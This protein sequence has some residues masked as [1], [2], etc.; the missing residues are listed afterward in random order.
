MQLRICTTQMHFERMFVQKV[1]K[2]RWFFT[3]YYLF[4]THSAQL[5]LDVLSMT[6][7]TKTT[8]KMDEQG[9][10]PGTINLKSISAPY[11]GSKLFRTEYIVQYRTTVRGIN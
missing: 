7:K 8:P 5:S 4:T 3:V 11:E 10:P 9:A 6:T 1:V 2:T